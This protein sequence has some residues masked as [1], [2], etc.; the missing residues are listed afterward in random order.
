MPADGEEIERLR[1]ENERLRRTN[2]ELAGERTAGAGSH[3]LRRTLSW[4]VVVVACAL[5]AISVLVVFV[6]NEVLN[7]A[8]Y[9]AMVAP[10][11]SEP[12]IQAAVANEVSTQLVTRVDLRKEIAD[13]LPPKAGFLAAPLA[14]GVQDAVRSATQ[15]VVE[16]PV[17]QTFWTEANRQAHAQLVALLTGSSTGALHA[18]RNGQVSLNLSQV[19]DQVKH[20]LDERGITLFDKVPT[21]NDTQLVLFQSDQL[22]RAQG[23]VRTLARLAL[24]LPLVTLAAFAGA[25]L[26]AIDRRR[27]LVRAAT[28]LAV[29]MVTLLVGF[30]VG[31]SQY[32]GALGPSVSRGAA[33]AAYDVVTAVPLDT[34]RA[35]LAV[36]AVVALLGQ[37]AGNRWLRGRLGALG[38]PAWLVENPVRRIVTA[39]RGA[40][41][42][43]LVG[44]GALV[45]VAW[46]N[47][48]P[49]TVVVV[50]MV[51][52]AA[53]GAAGL[54]AGG[55]GRPGHPAA[56]SRPAG[57]VGEPTS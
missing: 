15:S 12:A 56:P 27:G 36:A 14:S 3:R 16:S 49:L 6:R 45:V 1:K 33:E 43:G 4:I 8:T 31:R 40:V 38:R 48:T 19:A 25:V 57:G 11:A 53:V 9:V 42:W 51:T 50:A 30:D 24:V 34:I 39:H 10:L 35:I 22:A 21:G 55:T 28:G 32:L 41:Q 37:L 20:R 54:L 26:L 47:P 29:T 44:L 46:A 7:T 52:L 5:A 18:D 2:A 17:F 23:L 13:V